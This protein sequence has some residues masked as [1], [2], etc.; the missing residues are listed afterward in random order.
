MRRGF[1]ITGLFFAVTCVIGGGALW[2]VKAALDEKLEATH[3]SFLAASN[4]MLPTYLELGADLDADAFFTTP[5]PDADAGP[6]LNPRVGWEGSKPAPELQIPEGTIAKLKELKL[7]WLDH[8]DELDISKLDFSWMKGLRAFGHWNLA[9]DSPITALPHPMLFQQLPMP[10]FE[11][12]DLWAR[13]RFVAA[14]RDHDWLEASKD[15]QHL[16][17]LMASTETQIGVL[18][19]NRVLVRD[20]D[21]R[22]A[23]IARGEDVTGW[24][25]HTE[26]WRRELIA[27]AWA[28][29]HFAL[30]WTSDEN[31]ATA[32]TVRA[33]RCAGL[34]DAVWAVLAHRDE[35]ATLPA[36]MESE[37]EQP[38]SPCRLDLAHWYMSNGLTPREAELQH[39]GNDKS[40]RYLAVFQPR[41]FNG[42]LEGMD[43]QEL[44]KH[45][46]AA[47][48][49]LKKASP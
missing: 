5:R 15:V 26:R 12:L 39:P 11:L 34:T 45:F 40:G 18:S 38:G 31:R 22:L 6:W 16:A 32:R 35:K 14:L 21:A 48:V 33:T 1:I 47:L 8:A 20:D 10:D 3:Q 36:A 7:T 28:A 27:A 49:E 9:V 2:W 44:A 4:R 13:L 23:A 19:V 29:P 43:A 30:P 24:R 46:D 37:Y 41:F 42:L 17:W 25:V